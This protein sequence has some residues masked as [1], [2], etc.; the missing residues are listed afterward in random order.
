MVWARQVLGARK[1]L[2]AAWCVVLEAQEDVAARLHL[3]VCH[4]K[5]V[6]SCYAS[7]GLGLFASVILSAAKDL[8]ALKRLERQPDPS[9]RSG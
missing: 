7:K 9:L 1:Y 4:S 6:I 8:V 2:R 5:A 3:P